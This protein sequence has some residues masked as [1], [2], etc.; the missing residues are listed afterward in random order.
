MNARRRITAAHLVLA[1]TVGVLLLPGPILVAAPR[2]DARRT[3]GPLEV[4]PDDTR[5]GLF[6][7]PPGE[8]VLSSQNG[9]PD[10]HLLIA[11]YLGSVVGGDSGQTLLRGLVSF[12][13]EE[14]TPP[15]A[16]VDAAIRALAGTSRRKIELQ[17]LPLRRLEAALVWQPLQTTTAEAARPLTGGRFEADETAPPSRGALFKARFFTLSLSSADA[18]VLADSLRYGRL[19]FSLGYAFYVEG[20]AASTEILE[21]PPELVAE[22]R[23][24]L[25]ERGQVPGTERLVKAGALGI[26]LDLEAHPQ[27]LQKVDLNELAPPAWALVEVYCFDF[28]DQRRNDLVEKSVELKAEGVAG[29]EVVTSAIFSSRQRELYA[30]TLRFPLAVRLD[31]PYSFR[32]TEIDWSGETRV[33]PWQISDSWVR[34]LDISSPTTSAPETT[35]DNENEGDRQDVP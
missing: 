17:P 4:Y 18:Q 27:M 34:L 23:R 29:G 16:E 19:L 20:I 26:H 2:L 21:G 15:P 1:A 3:A 8:L 7:L 28:A 12:R 10:F 25:A 35:E 32:V 9:A 14:K 22:L 33:S 31:R 6:Y 5:P 30:S 24:Q 13:V 11:R